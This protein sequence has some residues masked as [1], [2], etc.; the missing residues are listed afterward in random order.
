MGVP[1]LTGTWQNRNA[2]YYQKL[3]A[4]LG[5][6]TGSYSQNIWLLQQLDKPNYGLP[7]PKPVAKP[8]TAKPVLT[9]IPIAQQY[10]EPAVKQAPSIPQWENVLPWEKLKS[11][12]Q[13]YF[14]GAA[15]GYVGPEV[16]RQYRQNLINY[17]NNLASSGGGRFGRGL[18]GTGSLASDA[19]RSLQEQMLDFQN[20][21]NQALQGWYSGTG[22]AYGKAR[23]AG[24]VYN[25][26]VPTY[27]EFTGGVASPRVGSTYKQSTSFNTP[28]FGNTG[29]PQTTPSKSS[30]Y[31]L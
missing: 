8:V 5:P 29:T 30:S 11:Q 28:V 7:T 12:F 26:K 22:S 3:G 18:G 17:M 23:D 2:Q 4:P 25:Y 20:Q 19:Q 24:D 13:P 16:Q 21:Y 9:P 14:Q 10:A 6:Y 15:E 27:A 1:G 31:W